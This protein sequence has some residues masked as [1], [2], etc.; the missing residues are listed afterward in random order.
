M[1]TSDS[2][3]LLRNEV[4]STWTTE[5]GLPQNFVTA[6]AQTPD[7]FLWV[8]TLNGLA[9]FD[10][11]HFRGFE[12]DGPPELQERILKLVRDNDGGMWIASTTGLFH[13]THNRFVTITIPGNSHVLTQALARTGDGGV[14]IVSD[15]RLMRT[16]GDALEAVPL[17]SNTHVVRDLFENKDGVLWITDGEHVVAVQ[18]DHSVIRYNN[19]GVQLIAELLNKFEGSSISGH[20]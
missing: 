2:E 5:Q 18:A 8:G 10:G 9:R 3:P 19:P 7:G 6:L 12:K 14:W 11:V 1:K 20:R 15:D 16:R 17:P 13:Y 4:L